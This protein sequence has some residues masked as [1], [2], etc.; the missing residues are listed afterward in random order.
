MD[1]LPLIIGKRSARDDRS[2]GGTIAD[3]VHCGLVKECF[4]PGMPGT[5]QTRANRQKWKDDKT[6]SEERIECTYRAVLAGWTFPILHA[7]IHF[8]GRSSL[9]WG[10][11]TIAGLKIGD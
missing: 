11:R 7:I 4:Q 2:Y 6:G 3:A 10:E 1:G 9:V 5:K 8:N